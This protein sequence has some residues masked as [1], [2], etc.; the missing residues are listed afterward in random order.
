MPF[1][2]TE[3]DD[4]FSRFT[5]EVVNGLAMARSPML[6]QIGPPV[7]DSTTVG[8]R[9]QSR[10]GVELDLPGTQVGFEFTTEVATVRS[11]NVG[12]YA[13][14][15]DAAA[16]QLERNLVKHIFATLGKVTE[17]TGNVVSA[18][19]RPTFEALYDRHCST[20]LSLS[21]Q[22]SESRSK[23]PSCS[24]QRAESLQQR[25]VPWMGSSARTFSC[26]TRGGDWPF[27][28]G[29]WPRGRSSTTVRSASSS[30]RYEV[31]RFPW[32]QC[33]ARASY[34]IR[35]RAAPLSD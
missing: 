3:Y 21:P 32:R 25:C 29:S 24:P 17:A 33:H 2:L 35:P 4:A 10:D 8:S 27:A 20:R 31:S 22:A 19:G 23:M 6:T 30:R 16:E 18:A 28:I 26:A 14:Q 5:W 7:W 12:A 9:V 11:G 1:K 13:Q 34:A 15:L